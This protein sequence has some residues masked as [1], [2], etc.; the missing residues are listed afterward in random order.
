[1]AVGTGG[2]Y[3]GGGTLNGTTLTIVV[4]SASPVNVTFASPAA[5][6]AVRDVVNAALGFPLMRLGTN[7]EVLSPTTGATSN[8]TL[9]GTA[10]PLLG[11]VAPNNTSVGGYSVS[12]VSIGTGTLT[13]SFFASSLIQ[14]FIRF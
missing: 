13:D 14:L 1:V 2:L 4:D 12:S 9:T 5:A 7:F 8:I 10:A 11:F 3:G 6:A